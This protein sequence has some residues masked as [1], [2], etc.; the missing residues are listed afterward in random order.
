MMVLESSGGCSGFE[1][2]GDFGLMGIQMWVVPEGFAALPTDIH[3]TIKLPSFI[4][5]FDFHHGY[6][7]EDHRLFLRHTLFPASN[8]IQRH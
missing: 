2:V 6:Q 3:V 1:L 8:L 7:L 4:M 5:D